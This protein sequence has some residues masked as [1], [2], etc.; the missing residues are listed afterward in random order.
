M[1]TLNQLGVLAK[2]W[3]P[4]K[5]K[6]RL[7]ASIGDSAAAMLSHL[8]LIATLRRVDTFSG[9]R[10]LAYSPE[11]RSEAF[12]Q[13]VDQDWQL[14]PQS[15]GDLGQRMSAYFQDA[16]AGGADRVVLIGSDSPSLPVRRFEDAFHAL[17]VHDLVLG[18]SE[19]G[20]YYLIGMRRYIPEVFESIDWSTGQVYEQTVNVAVG[21][22]IDYASLPTWYDVDVYEDLLRLKLDLDANEDTSDLADA[23]S[24]LLAAN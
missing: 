21:H 22:C 16:F 17:D 6:T 14:K 3:Q 13:L 15:D 7:A 8:F 2:Y 23:L 12:R 5:T 20:G 10:V 1:G 9:R 19:D 4:G 24:K 11:E 18:P